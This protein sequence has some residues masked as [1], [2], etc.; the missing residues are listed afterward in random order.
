[1][2]FLDLGTE[3]LVKHWQ[4]PQ[5]VQLQ[6]VLLGPKHWESSRIKG[7]GIPSGLKITS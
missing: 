2:A 6:M 1:M 7:M 3:K 5:M 4:S